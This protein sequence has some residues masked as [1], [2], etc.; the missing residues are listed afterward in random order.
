MGPPGAA[1]ARRRTRSSTT[2]GA[3]HISTGDI[4]RM[5]VR[6]GDE[7]GLRVEAVLDAG[8]LVPDG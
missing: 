8:D 4:L 6:S 2:K 7:L 1:R 5:A 3:V